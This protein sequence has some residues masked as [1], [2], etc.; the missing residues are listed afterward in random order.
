VVEAEA[1]LPLR[2]VGTHARHTRTV[3]NVSCSIACEKE[4]IEARPVRT[5]FLRLS[6]C[7]ALL[8]YVR[9]APLLVALPVS[10]GKK[11]SSVGRPT[12]ALSVPLQSGPGMA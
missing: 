4:G 6:S 2:P 7:C 8:T 10:C 1:C 3:S 12:Q 5:G 11:T 9:V